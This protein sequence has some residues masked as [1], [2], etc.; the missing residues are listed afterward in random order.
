MKT[1]FEAISSDIRRKILVYLVSSERT[2]GEIAELFDV[3]GPAISQHLA[4]LEDAGLV[5]S[6]RRARYVYYR[7][8]PDHLTS[9]LQSF[10]EESRPTSAAIDAK[11]AR[12]RK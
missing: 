12:R 5:R 2:S 8:V 9:E 1:V 7:L 4:V 10:V 3:S 6:E 11:P